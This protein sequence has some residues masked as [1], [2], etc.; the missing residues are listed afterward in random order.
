[1]AHKLTL[2]AG[3]CLGIITNNINIIYHNNNVIL[4][5]RDLMVNLGHEAGK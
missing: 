4:S 3:A 5:V 2:V 1:M